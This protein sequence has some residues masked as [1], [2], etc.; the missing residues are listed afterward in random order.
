[1]QDPIAPA[2]SETPTPQLEPV[3]GEML[4]KLHEANER[5]STARH[6]RE[7]AIDDSSTEVGPRE[8]AAQ[9]FRD[10]EKAIE[11]VTEEIDRDLHLRK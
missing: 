1:M 9:E 3:P 5:F 7:D 8:R 10:A 6:H 4:D 11:E 2:N